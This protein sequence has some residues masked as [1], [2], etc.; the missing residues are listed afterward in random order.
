[1]SAPVIFASDVDHRRHRQPVAQADLV[2]GGIV[3]RRHLDRARAE[4]AIDRC[5][6]DDRNRALEQR[7]H[8][9]AAPDQRRITFVVRMNGDR[10]VGENRFRT[11]GRDRSVDAVAAVG[12]RIGD[13]PQ[14]RIA[15]DVLDLRI[16][17]RRLPFGSQL[18]RRL[19]R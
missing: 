11:R 9:H 1:M 19:P 12:E 4:A 17:D 3:R 5:V 10:D 8:Q 18:I 6:G 15:F 13:V 7:R 14:R 16:R 2:V